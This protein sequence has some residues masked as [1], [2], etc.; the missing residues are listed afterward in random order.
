[1]ALQVRVSPASFFT[2]LESSSSLSRCR[3]RVTADLWPLRARPPARPQVLID[4][5]SG[6]GGSMLAT[7][8][9]YPFDVA[10]VRP[11]VGRLPS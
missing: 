5:L 7:A 1:M 2:A 6:T 3:S 11:P 10:K 9:M 8:A 4:G